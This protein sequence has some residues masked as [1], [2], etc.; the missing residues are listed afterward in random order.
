MSRCSKSKKWSAAVQERDK[1]VC[2][3]CGE[4]RKC[5]LHAHHIVSW[6]DSIELRFEISNGITLCNSCHNKEHLRLGRFNLGDWCRGKKLTETHKQK[7]REAKI[8]NIPWNKGLKG[9]QASTRKGTKQ[10]PRTEEV[11]LKIGNAT[12]GRSW[13]I[14]PETGKRIWVDK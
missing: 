12:R 6:D 1:W 3:H 11:K 13:I 5:K 4:V 2:L 8:G 10:A 9:V 14:N 7:L